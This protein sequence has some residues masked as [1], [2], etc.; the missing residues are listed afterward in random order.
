MGSFDALCELD[1]L[2]DAVRRNCSITDARHARDMTMCNYLLEMREY[3][4]WE[5]GI[6]PGGILPPR[7]EIGTWLIAREAL[8]E[9]LVGEDYGIVPV[10]GRNH[11]PFESDAI[12]QALQGH[13]LI[14]GA[15]IGRFRKPHFFLGRLV[16]EDKREGLRVLVCGREYAR[17]LTAFPAVLRGDTIVVR[18]EALRQW[19][20]EKVEAWRAK[21]SEGALKAALDSYGY[22]ADARDAI[23]L[24]AEA[25]TEVL[26]LHELGEH[27]AGRWLSPSWEA[28]LSSCRSKRAEVVARA[29][30][31]NLADCLTTLPALLERDA[32]GSLHF[33]FANFDGMRH[34]LF[35]SLAAAYRVWH[36]NLD[37]T[38]LHR[39]L[40]EG[41][42][43][44]RHVAEDILARFEQGEEAA[45]AA[46]AH[47]G[48]DPAAILL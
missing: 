29:V 14:Y 31:D 4:R 32:R 38:L 20:W 18:G 15:G 33:W 48:N 35:P 9:E 41:S 3:C 24:M 10:G 8:W 12:N 7:S 40:S 6:P 17:D 27:A 26:V 2:V 43:H 11:D 30:R 16:R 25:E 45:D 42:S 34:E 23:E 37:A 36:A 47:W 28:M 46:L 39:A 1:R 13:G 22:G 21:H 5:R 44:W 19:L